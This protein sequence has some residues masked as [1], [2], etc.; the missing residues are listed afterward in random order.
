MRDGIWESVVTA[1]MGSSNEKSFPFI[2]H[3]NDSEVLE[4]LTNDFNDKVKVR[5]DRLE[6]INRLDNMFE[7]E[8][9]TLNRTRGVEADDSVN[10][11]KVSIF[12]M[13][14]EM[15]EAK[16][17]QRGKNKSNIQV[18]PSKVDLEDENKAEAVKYVLSAKAREKNMESI[19]SKGD[20]EEFI[21]GESYTYI[22]W[23]KYL[24]GLT[25]RIETDPI[26]GAQYESAPYYRGDFDIKVLGPDK[27]FHQLSKDRWEDVEDVSIV[28]W[29]H[30]DEI[31]AEYPNANNLE[32]GGSFPNEYSLGKE[33]VST[34]H[35][36]VITFFMKP[37]KF[38]PTGAYYKFCYNT[39]LEGG[40]DYPYK[41]ANGLPSSRLPVVYGTD[42]DLRGKIGGK[43]FTS[44][45]ERL[46]R[47]HD[48]LAS[49]TARGY[50]VGNSPKWVVPKGSV[51]YNK[52]NN[53]YSV[54]EY[55]GPIKPELVSFTA[56]PQ[57]ADVMMASVERGI[58]KGSSVGGMLRGETP[59]GIESAVALQFLS[60]Q[61]MV[62]ES[63]GM[64]KRQDRALA[65]YEMMLERIQQFYTPEDERIFK[66]LGEDNEY[67]VRSMKDL[68]IT[69][70]YNIYFENSSSLPD[71]KS[72]RI[73]SI[74]D[75]NQANPQDPLFSREQIAQM[76]DLGND[77]RFRTEAQASLKAA[78]AKLQKIL[79]GQVA[80]PKDWDDFTTEYPMFVKALRE[81]TYKGNRPE[82][83]EA[84]IRYITG[85][86]ALI[87]QKA[88]LNP[89]YK[90]GII[91][92]IPEYPIFMK[93]PLIIPQPEVPPAMN[94]KPVQNLPAL[95]QQQPKGAQVRNIN[96]TQKGE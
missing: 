65:I 14:N 54:M 55:R 59:K 38:L 39:L 40:L 91:R 30:I 31:R 6:L 62:K 13:V 52:L 28:E 67:L 2:N 96:N 90:E 71:S 56:I 34:N 5:L 75:L 17:S 84:L 85:M 42:I 41:L 32:L 57:G 3:D 23:D 45:I 83:E 81:R 50:A 68:D 82:V 79:T 60:E 48:M 44:N 26:T 46:Q 64:A 51:D 10:R 78:Q 24:G 29:V 49:S 16:M 20:K 95:N 22:P 33:R 58:E 4:W 88:M 37:T 7:G 70:D 63:N 53:N 36:M 87:Y 19:L 69:G 47:L 93:V 73:A 77:K 61:E 27:C 8:P 1:G 12:N 80:E 92:M 15:V 43:P 86:E 18:V 25:K 74:I 11:T 76:L 21:A 35:L 72:G 66:Y 9:Y 94:N 89:V